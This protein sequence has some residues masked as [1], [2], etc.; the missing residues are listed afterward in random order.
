MV[1]LP[2]LLSTLRWEAGVLWGNGRRVL[3]SGVTFF[4][5]VANSEILCDAQW[6]PACSPL[7]TVLCIWHCF[8]CMEG[9]VKH[10]TLILG[11]IALIINFKPEFL[12]QFLIRLFWLNQSNFQAVPSLCWQRR[13]CIGVTRVDLGCRGCLC[14]ITL[15]GNAC[16]LLYKETC[17]R[18]HLAKTSDCFSF[19]WLLLH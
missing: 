4:F 11:E 16:R 18:E 14:E 15:Q 9:E 6:V 10:L 2:G 8:V 5:T 7:Q 17:E 12:R 3:L 1:R 13:D 19:H